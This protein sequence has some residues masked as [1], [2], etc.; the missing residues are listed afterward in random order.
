MSGSEGAVTTYIVPPKTKISKSV[1]AKFALI[2]NHMGYSYISQVGPFLQFSPPKYFT[3]PFFVLMR[4]IY[5]AHIIFTEL[6][7]IIIY[8]VYKS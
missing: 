2:T 4:A 3:H 5:P 7:T 1:S 6:M 8:D